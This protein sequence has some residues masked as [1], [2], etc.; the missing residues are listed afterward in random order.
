M[1]Q[2]RLQKHASRNK[3]IAN[4]NS[5]VI[6]EGHLGGKMWRQKGESSTEGHFVRSFENKEERERRMVVA[7]Y[8]N[9][10]EKSTWLKF[11][12][13]KEGCVVI[14]VRWWS[15]WSRAWWCTALDKFC[16]A[17]R[18]VGV[19]VAM[20]LNEI[21]NFSQKLYWTS[22]TDRHIPLASATGLVFKVIMLI[23]L[24]RKSVV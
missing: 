4:C 1:E 3:R 11:S 12:A 21:E 14:R 10:Y 24:D 2:R 23:N 7:N 20:N 16:I 22:Q 17:E 18:G 19:V 6:R 9:T 5:P 8:S 13:W 15:C